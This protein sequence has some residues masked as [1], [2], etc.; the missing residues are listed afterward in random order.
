MNPG[1]PVEFINNSEYIYKPQLFQRNIRMTE[2]HNLQQRLCFF[3]QVFYF[4]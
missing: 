3:K 4:E 1:V 2:Q